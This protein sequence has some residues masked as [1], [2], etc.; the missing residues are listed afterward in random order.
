M[1]KDWR[2]L[3]LRNIIRFT[4]VLIT[5]YFAWEKEAVVATVGD[6]GGEKGIGRFIS[7]SRWNIASQG[8]V[9]KGGF[10]VATCGQWGTGTDY[11]MRGWDMPKDKYY[12]I[13]ICFGRLLTCYWH[14]WAFKVACS[15]CGAVKRLEWSP[16]RKDKFQYSAYY[17]QFTSKQ[18]LL[19][20][21]KFWVL[22]EGNLEEQARWSA[23]QLSSLV[24]QGLLFFTLTYHY[25]YI[26]SY[27]LWLCTQ[28][29]GYLKWNLSWVKF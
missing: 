1:I 20:Y 18:L 4:K 29:L 24:L 10:G 22:L 16:G 2:G 25:K 17:Y 19:I 28:L 5:G 6:S 9:Y 23:N 15:S 26:M 7:N 27:I 12:C 14:L 3:T 11:G 8:G 21:G 13:M